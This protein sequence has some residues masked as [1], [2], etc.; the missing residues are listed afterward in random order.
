MPQITIQQANGDQQAVIG[1]GKPL[2]M[3]LEAAGSKAV[4]A[5]CR[6]GGC[7]ICRVQ[8]LSGD[9]EVKKMS[10]AHV[11]ENDEKKGIVLACRTIPQGDL[12]LA[13]ATPTVVIKQQQKTQATNV[14][15]P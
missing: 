14:N 3:A 10:R 7:G 11:S 13:L 1:T 9:Y 12:V 6:G 8:I 15:K 4:P 2:L 5:G